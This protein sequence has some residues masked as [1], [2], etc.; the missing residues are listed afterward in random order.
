VDEI[1]E[2]KTVELRQL[3]HKRHTRIHVVALS[4]SSQVQVVRNQRHSEFA[5]PQLEQRGGRVWTG[6][7]RR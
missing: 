1:R 5:E 6:R 2:N 3:T 7:R 4:Y